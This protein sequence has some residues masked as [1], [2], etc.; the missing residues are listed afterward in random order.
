MPTKDGHI[1]IPGKGELAMLRSQQNKIVLD[2]PREPNVITSVPS[3]GR[4]T[5]FQ[6]GT[7]N[8]DSGGA[9]QGSVRAP[10]APWGRSPAHPDLSPVRCVLN[11]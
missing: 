7:K 3:G 2:Y 5:E 6:L 11:F 1:R 9:S 8:K 4:G 10:R